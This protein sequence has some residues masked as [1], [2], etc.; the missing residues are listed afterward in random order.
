LSRASPGPA[1]LLL[2]ALLLLPAAAGAQ[3]HDPDYRWHTIDTPHFLVHYHQGLE[4]LA[5][6][7]ARVAERAHA[8]LAPALGYSPAERTHL[9]LSDDSDV[10]NGWATP[11]PYNA[12]HVYTVP[13]E[14]GS[15]LN[16]ERDWLEAVITHEYVHILHLD[17]VGGIP[18]TVNRI[19]GKIWPPNALTP[20]WLIEGVAVAHEAP[21][22][23]GAGRNE[24]ALF[25]TY[26]RALVVEPPGFPSL[27]QAS[28]PYLDWPRGNIPYLVGG[29][30]MAWLEGRSGPE[31]MKAFLADQGSR[32]W[33]WTPSWAAERW[34]GA[35]L[36]T[37]WARFGEELRQGYATQLDGVRQRPVTRPAPLTRRGGLIERPRWLPDGS[38][39]VYVDRG[40]D[41]RAGLRRVT[42]AGQ[43]L[44]RVLAVDL[45]GAFA[46]RSAAEA[47][48]ARGQVWHEYRL[49]SDLYLADLGRG[50]D[51]RLT[52][53]ERA[54]DPALTPDGRQVVYVAQ[55][56]AGEQALRRRGVDGG[57]A[58][59]LLQLPGVQ[60]YEPAISPDGR[61]IALSIQRA[62]RRD[63]VILEDGELR[64]VTSDDALDRAP[65]W[66]PDGRW[67]L[68]C[69]DRGGL[70]NLYAWEA[71][72]G[73]VRQVTNVESG[74]FEPTVSPDGAT[75]AFVTYSRRGYDLATIPFDPAGWLDPAPAP[76][77]V[78]PP[79]PAPGPDL[80]VRPY[81]GAESSVPSYWLPTWG[82]DGAGSVL[83]F[84][85]M[86]TDVLARHTWSF[87]AWAG[88]DL[89]TAGY[90]LSYV[91][92][93]SWPSLDFYSTF[94]VAG[95]PGY[96]ARLLNVSTPLAA[97]ATFTF[98]RLERQ[99]AFRVGWT[100][101][102]IW[103][104]GPMPPLDGAPP[105]REFADG[106][107]SE[108]ALSVAYGDARRY[109][110]SISTEEG[111]SL[112]LRLRY[113]G[114]AT[115]SDY[116]L[117]RA[118]AAWSEFTRIPFT[119][120][121]VLASRLSGAIGHGS[122]GGA[123]PFS[124]GGMP[125]T[126][127]LSLTPLQAFS[128][129]DQLRGYPAGLFAGNGTFSAS[130][131]LRFPLLSPELGYSTAPV[132]LRR[133]HGA[134]FADLGEAFV[135][136]IERGYAG[137]DFHW[138]RLRAGAGVELRLETA[139]AYWLLTD[140]RLGVARGL[141][142]PLDHLGPTQDPYA[143]WQWYLVLGP[144]F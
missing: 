12:I 61:R 19:F 54:A 101:S 130:F 122:L 111:R 76:P 63:L 87:D 82:S 86:G 57:P 75:L 9:V 45:G 22:E 40:L 47:V 135:Q 21:G 105:G 88:K 1:R 114:P 121:V 124:L 34:F 46:L 141:G 81:S 97:G 70:Y 143:V 24:S 10:A 11:F 100:P 127:L 67:L 44:G 92:G 14:S 79:E 95:S 68:F 116:A 20:A 60:L 3:P 78:A 129:S 134:L 18:A 104:A 140:V 58:E 144:S 37:L 32:V 5:Q 128:P 72:S 91:G 2:L 107:L 50:T 136:G 112:T 74:A 80:P 7:A 117:W 56:G 77:A 26:L 96:P 6:R 142:K 138:R 131:E 59:T 49:Y 52:D 139:L 93:W 132:F 103:T 98:T 125:A 36:P 115:G 73:T 41:E 51:R 120:H 29:R 30:F 62:G 109:P 84:Y 99:L 4:A 17:H 110:R 64:D 106:L 85:T 39:L 71:A 65:A 25:D 48:V 15:E 42:R 102:I 38:G 27:A 43:D 126:N 119:R 13:A 83:G 89:L 66:S 35:D 8:R 53:G 113:A 69:S 33:P 123:P 133:L 137:P 55:A 23:I 28:N 16:D 31:A 94:Y 90:A 108:A 118:R